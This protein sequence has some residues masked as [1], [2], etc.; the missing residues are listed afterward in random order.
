MPRRGGGRARLLQKRHEPTGEHFALTEKLSELVQEAITRRWSIIPVRADKRPAISSW[1]E[2]QRRRA[3]E[4]EIANWTARNPDA[5]AVVTGEVSGI[6]ILDFDGENG[7]KTMR[8]LGI[9]PHV[10]T[11]SGG[12]HAYFQHPGHHV[13]TLNS[14]SKAELGE[15][16]PGLDIRADGGYAVFAGRNAS[17]PYKW[18]RPLEPD[19]I[20][21][22][23]AE[24]RAYLSLDKPLAYNTPRFRTNGKEV[25]ASPARGLG[26]NDLINRAWQRAE[27]EGR[28]NAGFWLACQLRDREVSE[29]EAE[30]VI[31]RYAEGV[32][33]TNTKGQPEP[34]TSVDAIKSLRKA[35]ES[36]RR[37]RPKNRSSL[38]PVAQTATAQRKESDHASPRR[39]RFDLRADGLFLIGGENQKDRR[40]APRIEVIAHARNSQGG[41][42]AKYLRFRNWEGEEKH[43]FIPVTDFYGDRSTGFLEPLT[44]AGFLPQR[45][46]VNSLRDYLLTEDPGK[47]VRSTS[48]SGWHGCRFV[49]P[50]VSIGPESAEEVIFRAEAISD[51]RFCV[52]GT[53]HEWQERIGLKCRGNSRLLFSVCC[54]LAAPVLDIV[55]AE[56]AGFHFRGLSSTGKTTALDVGGSVCGG[57]PQHGYKQTWRAT[58]N[59]LE[60]RGAQHNHLL[61][62]LDEIGEVDEKEV[63]EIVYAL[64]N[65]LGKSRMSKAMT[66]RPTTQHKLVLLSTGE[67][68]LPDVMKAGKK[69]AK[70]GQEVRLVEIE[71]DAGAGMGLF[72]NLHGADGPSAFAQE[73]RQATRRYYGTPLRAWLTWLT[74]NRD[75]ASE[76]LASIRATFVRENAIE[77]ASGEVQRVLSSL[78]LMGAAGELASPGVT[79][80]NSGEAL[81]AARRMFNAWIA[82]RGGTGSRDIDAG[83][84]ALKTFLLSQ[85]SRFQDVTD[86]NNTVVR[87]RAG[88]FKD[89]GQDRNYYI[90]PN[91]FADEICRE[92]DAHKIAKELKRRGM[93]EHD[94]DRL[95]HRMRAPDGSNV[96][97]YAIRA[98]FLNG[99][100]EE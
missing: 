97:Y 11:G 9:K 68:T 23:P 27:N 41:Q 79:G 8:Q 77:G 2:Y 25:F 19:L 48:T 66:L 93:L 44:D 29:G 88:Y 58:K 20:D 65:G 96:R 32:S 17:G 61:L 13:Q 1:K 63:G 31:R 100:K 24:V 22:L 87:D 12:A 37:E 98:E 60:A 94:G 42:A 92:L 3:T 34:Y 26:Q 7:K 16:Y 78:G 95:M 18:L 82:V 85:A 52:A 28:N 4:V 53:L 76:Q 33:S 74:H 56:G 83:I 21:I 72:E 73:L 70:G 91:V 30:N 50:D 90:F 54:A 86:R 5:W 6:V 80:W 43:V 67:R 55:Q 99:E 75:F 15:R 45:D 46:S 14:K 40:I 84:G 57:N 35:F 81:E 47:W 49:L 39:K 10:A 71:A 62:C 36:P 51:H 59:G 38:I 89:V 69:T 64:A